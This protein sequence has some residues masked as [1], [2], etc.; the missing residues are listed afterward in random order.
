MLSDSDTPL[1][2]SLFTE[3]IEMTPSIGEIGG[4]FR[5]VATNAGVTLCPLLLHVGGLAGQLLRSM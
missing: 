3:D 4:G 2:R 5:V 1:A